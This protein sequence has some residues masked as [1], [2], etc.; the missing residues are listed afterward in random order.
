MTGF[1]IPLP[2]EFVRA[3]AIAVA[4][5][6]TVPQPIPNGDPD[7]DAYTLPEAAKR[8]GVS[9]DHFRRHCLPEIRFIRSGRLRLIP[10]TELERWVRE[11]AARFGER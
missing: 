11:C 2:P 1:N 9:D 7:R 3:L 4:K 5:E 10:R 6:I 8:L